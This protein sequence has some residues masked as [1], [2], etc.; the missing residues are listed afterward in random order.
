MSSITTFPRSLSVLPN[1]LP[2]L[3]RAIIR[4]GF[5]TQATF[6]E[7]I[8][9]GVD[10]IRKFRQ[11][12]AIS[13]RNFIEICEALELDWQD[14]AFEEEEAMA[15]GS[16][17]EYVP[18]MREALDDKV[19]PEP[20]ILDAEVEEDTEA[21]QAVPPQKE[22]LQVTQTAHINNGFMIGNVQGDLKVRSPQDE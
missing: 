18:P 6:A 14:W 17:G 13:R 5:D 20:N 10:T 3:E 16:S 15:D 2:Q 9:I 19:I 22:G 8:N 1:K 21:K 4:Q 7:A 11:G 12:K